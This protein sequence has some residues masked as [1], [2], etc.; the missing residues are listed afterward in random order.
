MYSTPSDDTL[1]TTDSQA[2]NLIATNKTTRDFL[3]RYIS[4]ARK[5]I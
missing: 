2:T 3:A 5:F 4:Y 1:A